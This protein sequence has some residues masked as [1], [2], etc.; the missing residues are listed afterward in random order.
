MAQLTVR[1]VDPSL[2]EALKARAKAAGRSM[3]AEHRRL[4]EAALQGGADDTFFA[5]AEARRLRLREPV[6][7]AAL[8]RADRNR[9][10]LR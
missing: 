7:L 3:E 2:V 9:D 10:G 6:D 4:L 8:I 5:R 1:N